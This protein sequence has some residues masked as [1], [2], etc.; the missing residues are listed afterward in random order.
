MKSKLSISFAASETY[1]SELFASLLGRRILVD[2]NEVEEP[3][4]TIELNDG[5]RIFG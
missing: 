1:D 2:E 3:I 5:L 4:E